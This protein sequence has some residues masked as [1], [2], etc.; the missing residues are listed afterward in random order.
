VETQGM[1][2]HLETLTD[3]AGPNRLITGDFGDPKQVFFK[4]M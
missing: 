3:E 1:A 2:S 4:M